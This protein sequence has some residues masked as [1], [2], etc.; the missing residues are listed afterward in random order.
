MKIKESP[1]ELMPEGTPVRGSS[2]ARRTQTAPRWTDFVTATS[3][4]ENSGSWHQGFLA[5]E[6]NR[7]VWQARNQTLVKA[8]GARPEAMPQAAA[9]GMPRWQTHAI[10]R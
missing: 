1:P 6:P 3:N 4:V 10:P 2:Q 8:D 9:N 7:G 5:Q